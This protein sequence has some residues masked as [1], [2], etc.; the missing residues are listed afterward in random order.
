M[1][2]IAVI[3]LLLAGSAYAAK[4]PEAPSSSK[5]KTPKLFWVATGIYAGA[6]VA[7]GQTTMRII[8]NGGVESWNSWLYGMRPTHARFYTTSTAMDG[9][10]IALS[11]KLIRSRRKWMRVAGWALLAGGIEEHVRGAIHNVRLPDR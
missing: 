4:L 8:N 10:Q 3:L 5:P 9:M 7:D 2:K 1:G 11:Y 6:I